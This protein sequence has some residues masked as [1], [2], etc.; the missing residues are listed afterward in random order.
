LLTDPFCSFGAE[1]SACG[2]V[3]G[4]AVASGDA[5]FHEMMLLVGT[6]HR[7]SAG[8]REGIEPG[9][10]AGDHVGEGP[11]LCPAEDTVAA[12]GDELGGGGEQS[13]S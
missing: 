8:V 9:R 6:G 7:L 5:G 2:Q 12:S 4:P 10:G 13:Q 3:D 1:I 11:V